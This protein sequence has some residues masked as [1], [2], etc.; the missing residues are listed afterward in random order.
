MKVAV[1]NRLSQNINE[2][3]GKGLSSTCIHRHRHVQSIL[4]AGINRWGG[5]GNKFSD[6]VQ[7]EEKRMKAER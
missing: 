6:D 7:T 1:A 3:V 2:R 5:R 4:I